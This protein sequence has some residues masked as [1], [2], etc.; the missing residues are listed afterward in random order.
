MIAEKKIVKQKQALVWACDGYQEAQALKGAL[1]SNCEFIGQGIWKGHLNTVTDDGKIID[2]PNFEFHEGQAYF[3]QPST[4]STIQDLLSDSVVS[5][6]ERF[7]SEFIGVG[8][9]VVVASRFMNGE[10]IDGV[11][12]GEI[13]SIKSAGETTQYSIAVRQERNKVFFIHAYRNQIRKPTNTELADHTFRHYQNWLSK[14]H[15]EIREENTL[16]KFFKKLTTFW[17]K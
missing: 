14:S 16:F 13:C 9:A 12:Y 6:Q 3:Y 4:S 8:E 10:K 15:L 2:M 5:I 11:L 1:V 17:R 7:V